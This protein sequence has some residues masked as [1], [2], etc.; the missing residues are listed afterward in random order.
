MYFQV[1]SWHSQPIGY[2]KFTTELYK[3][4]RSDAFAAKRTRPPTLSE[5]WFGYVDM[6]GRV[7]L[8]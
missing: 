3:T 6:E 5:M 8:A 7:I 1:R 4:R 2:K